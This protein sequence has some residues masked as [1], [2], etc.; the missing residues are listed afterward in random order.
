[1]KYI[2]IYEKFNL[3]KLF[4]QF[5]LSHNPFLLTFKPYIGNETDDSFVHSYNLYDIKD[6]DLEL[7]DIKYIIVSNYFSSEDND[8][9]FY[10]I[11]KNNN[12]RKATDNEDDIFR[13]YEDE[14]VYFLE[15]DELAS[16]NYDDYVKSMKIDDKL[17]MENSRT[18][19]EK[20]DTT[21]IENTFDLNKGKLMAYKSDDVIS[22][23]RLDDEDEMFEFNFVLYRTTPNHKELRKIGITHFIIETYSNSNE[24]ESTFYAVYNNGLLIEI[25]NKELDEY[26]REYDEQKELR[27]DD[28][29]CVGVIWDYFGDVTSTKYSEYIDK[30]TRKDLENK[31]KIALDAEDYRLANN[32]QKR[33]NDL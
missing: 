20:L 28:S 30:F 29:S 3:T 7:E 22:I 11:D 25:A 23:K 21:K 16:I 8:Q 13:E 24:Y 19:I 26:F 31:L 12:I 15:M 5:V 10:V 14:G 1:M 2:K 27:D 17:A 32:I 6:T 9:E 4:K 33:L 18:F